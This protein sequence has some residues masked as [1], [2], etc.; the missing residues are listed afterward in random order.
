MSR[1]TT[2]DASRGGVVARRTRAR[3]QRLFEFCVHF[4]T[5]FTCEPPYTILS[6]IIIVVSLVWP[7][8]TLPSPPYSSLVPVPLRAVAAWLLVT[9]VRRSCCCLCCCCIV[10]WGVVAPPIGGRVDDGDRMPSAPT[11]R[12][13]AAAVSAL[14]RAGM[15]RPPVCVFLVC[16]GMRVWM[17][18]STCRR[19]EPGGLCREPTAQYIDQPPTHTQ[20][21]VVGSRG[22]RKGVGWHGRGRRRRCR[23]AYGPPSAP[24]A[25]SKTWPRPR[26]PRAASCG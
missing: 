12:R 10:P 3:L 24:W 23:G 16:G 6:I 19:M 25:R 20:A 5:L 21:P 1:A 26:G 17:D 9:G 4:L 18:V 22:R 7:A 13:D 14:G 8:T 2:D 15:T 11:I